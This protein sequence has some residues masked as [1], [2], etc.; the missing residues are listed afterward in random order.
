[1]ARGTVLDEGDSQAESPTKPSKARGDEP[2]HDQSGQPD[3]SRSANPRSQRGKVDPRLQA[4]RR[5][6]AR[7]AGRRRLIITA[8]IAGV[9]LLALALIAVAK[10]SLFNVESVVVSGASKV[11][12]SEVRVA[13]GIELGQALIDVNPKEVAARVQAVPWI[14]SARVDRQLM[15]RVEIE[16]IEHTP[17]MVLPTAARLVLVSEEGWQL[18]IVGEK[19]DSMLPVF[20][21]VESGV[22]GQRISEGGAAVL[23]LAAAIPPQLDGE[24]EAIRLENQELFV[25][26]MVGGR[27][28]IGNADQLDVKLSALNTVINRINVECIDT[29]DVRVPHA[30]TVS[31]ITEF[32]SA[33][34]P[35]V[36]NERC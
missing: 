32:F 16:V 1:M 31:R 29:V 15:S 17:A 10:S 23:A 22:P 11:D 28:R 19:P 30:P 18:E 2:R 34:E 33:K 3:D 21:V 36:G 14:A 7:A 5:N 4:R 9:A 12:P 6:V 13:S 8:S 25:D 35:G 26:L 20:G 27:A 24:I